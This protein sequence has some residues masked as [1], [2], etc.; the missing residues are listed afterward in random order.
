MSIKKS[1]F[2]RIFNSKI[3]KS[4]EIYQYRLRRFNINFLPTIR[5]EADAAL[6]FAAFGGAL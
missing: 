4:I 1:G 5:I 2:Q 6:S 3:N